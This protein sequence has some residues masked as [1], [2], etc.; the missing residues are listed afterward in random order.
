MAIRVWSDRD[1][2]W[3]ELSASEVGSLTPPRPIT[4]GYL[5]II[6]KMKAGKGAVAD[7]VAKAVARHGGVTELINYSD[8]MTDALRA[9]FPHIPRSREAYQKIGEA[10]RNA[11]GPDVW[12][13]GVDFCARQSKADFVV[14]AGMRWPPEVPL[15]RELP[16]S[17]IVYLTAPFEK[18]LEW[19]RI[20]A[21]RPGDAEKTVEQFANEHKAQTEIYV[22]QIGAQADSVI[23][24]SGTLEDLERKVR[25]LLR[26]RF[27]VD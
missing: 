20:K 24:N 14:L 5:G 7:I 8:R 27:G 3:Q 21:E 19:L 11:F 17:H 16:N 12:A 25:V 23:D 22:D 13:Q 1:G 15:V 18:R 6:A 4:R 10:A 9:G 2:C 26:D